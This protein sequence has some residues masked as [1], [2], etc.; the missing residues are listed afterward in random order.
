MQIQM[1][2][3]ETANSKTY[4]LGAISDL[5]SRLFRIETGGSLIQ[6]LKHNLDRV[7]IVTILSKKEGFGDWK[8]NSVTALN[9]VIERSADVDME[10]LIG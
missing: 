8:V 4:D 2:L 3:D 6:T 10:F 7:P 1:I 9:V 5:D